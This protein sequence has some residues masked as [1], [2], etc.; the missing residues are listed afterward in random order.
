[1]KLTN[2]ELFQNISKELAN[3]FHFLEDKPEETL[4]STLKALW[5]AASGLPVSAEESL[6]LQLPD[7]SEN[8]VV[9]LRRLIE[10]RHNGI[11]L[12]HITK[13]QN[14][15]GIE[16]ISDKRALIPRKETEILGNKA[17]ELAE[18]IGKSE[19]RINVFDVCCGSGNLGI[20]LAHYNTN[21]T[22][23]SSDL[24][25]EAVQ[26]TQDNINLMKL[27]TRI[28]VK[29][30]D[31]LTAFE[32]DEYY[33]KVNL[34]VCNPPYISSTKVQ[35]MDSEIS[36]NEPSLAFDGGMLGIRIIQK[37][38]AE[39]PRFLTNDGWVIFEVGAGQG[40]FIAQVCERTKLY[41]K[42][43][44]I[45]DKSGIIRVISLQKA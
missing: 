31:L 39:A 6:K 16:L 17:L 29:Q 22:V 11:P 5:F 36:S 42:I 15:L 34:I 24:S 18:E 43:N 13:R 26:L 3:S 19:A 28:Q 25:E 41:K 20:A 8:Q 10:L 45:P 38:I 27:N 4:E 23:S 21:C 1:M 40:D 12:A 35:K 9:E 30:S 7:L 14:F 33:G 37:L 32:S 2:L 44:L